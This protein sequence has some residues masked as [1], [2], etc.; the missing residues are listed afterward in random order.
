MYT[1]WLVF[2]ATVDS[3]GKKRNVKYFVELCTHSDA[4]C[5][6]KA[7]GIPFIFFSKDYRFSLKCSAT[8]REVVAQIRRT[9]GLKDDKPFNLKWLDVEGTCLSQE[10][11]CSC[12]SGHWNCSPA[13]T[14]AIVRVI[15]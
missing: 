13:V 6:L 7:H 8:V 1:W 2:L 10:L 4:Y 11:F 5:T 12:I 3:D 9:I 14:C 15:A